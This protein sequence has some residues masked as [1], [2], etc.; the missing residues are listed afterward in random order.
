LNILSPFV[1]GIPERYRSY[2]NGYEPLHGHFD[3]W[4]GSSGYI[5]DAGDACILIFAATVGFGVTGLSGRAL[6]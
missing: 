4:C 2:A 3:G 5:F 6:L 1:Y